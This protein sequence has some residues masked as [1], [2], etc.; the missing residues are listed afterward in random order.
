M[1]HCF[2]ADHFVLPL[3]D[4]HAF[5]MAKYRL[6][7]DQVA[8]WQPRGFRLMEAPKA[9][10]AAL[11]AVHSSDY[12]DAV[13]DGSLDSARL[14]RI[15]FPWSPF[16]AERARR[17]VGGTLAAVE[18]AIEH[19]VGVNLAGGTHHAHHDRGGG[20]CV[21]NDLAV[22]ARRLLDAG[23]A[24]RVAIIDLDVH[25]GDG[26]AALFSAEPQVWT[27][28]IHGEKIYPAIKPPGNL[29]IPLPA[30]VDDEAYL[31]ALMPALEQTFGEFR[32]DFVLFQAGADP[33]EGDRLGQF[34]LTM[35]GLARRDKA[36]LDACSR[37]QVPLAITM[38]GGYAHRIEDIVRIHANTIRLAH[39]VR[40]QRA[41]SRSFSLG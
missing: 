6:L 25:H 37:H 30:G 7:R 41:A 29:D 5:P 20:Y 31:G 26:T 18:A 35:A 15:G 36:V 9:S 12:V 13:L 34:K 22:A 17:T 8:A 4:G 3:P 2:Y 28:S 1:M 40:L 33:Y 11:K 16:M 21:F 14:R 27:L 39:A 19:G 23:Q 38:G 10:L 32:P 24:R